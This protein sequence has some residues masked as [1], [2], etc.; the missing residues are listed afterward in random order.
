MTL[1]SPTKTALLLLGQLIK[2]ARQQRSM[3]QRELA[4]RL[5]VSRQTVM[6]IETGKPNVAVG[7]VLEAA[8]IVGV[9][10]LSDDKAAL[11]QWQATLTGFKALL[12]ERVHSKK[13]KID[14]NF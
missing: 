11:T 1:S 8:H 13:V 9:P 4:E 3:S 6:A 5:G 2:T 10:L 14:D 7:T 12:P